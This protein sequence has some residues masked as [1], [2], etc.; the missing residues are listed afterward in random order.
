MVTETAIVKVDGRKSLESDRD[1]G[2]SASMPTRCK[3][4]EVEAGCI[5]IDLS[6]GLVVDESKSVVDGHRHGNAG[7]DGRSRKLGRP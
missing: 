5:A 1:A 4:T 3:G 7:D 2:L 6:T